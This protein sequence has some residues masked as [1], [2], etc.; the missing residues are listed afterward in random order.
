MEPSKTIQ[1]RNSTALMNN[2]SVMLTLDS[3]DDMFAQTTREIFASSP[4][5]VLMIPKWRTETLRTVWEEELHCV[6]CEE[7]WRLVCVHFLQS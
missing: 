1:A 2:S 7:N 4:I 5:A 3:L 6:Q